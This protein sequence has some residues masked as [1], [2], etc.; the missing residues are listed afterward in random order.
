[1]NLQNEI[2]QG[3]VDAGFLP[4]IFFKLSLG[5]QIA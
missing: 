5:I 3:I 4:A 1:L 2:E